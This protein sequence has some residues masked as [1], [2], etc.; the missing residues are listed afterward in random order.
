MAV[1]DSADFIGRLRKLLPAR[2]FPD[3]VPI[4]SA[5]LAGWAD[6]WAWLYAL[7]AYAKSQARISTASGIWL[8]IISSDFFAPGRMS[9]QLNEPDAAFAARI[10]REILRPRATR[11]AVSE[12]LVDLT[13]ITPKIFEPRNPSDTGGYNLGGVG[14]G[15]AGGWGD[16]LLPFQFFITAF[17]PSGG[18]VAK[19]AGYGNLHVGVTNSPGGYGSG[20]IQYITP[21]MIAGAVTDDAIYSTIAATIPA[22]TIA[23][24]QGLAAGVAG[25]GASAA[26]AVASSRQ[27]SSG[28]LSLALVSSATLTALAA[29]G[30]ATARA[31]ILFSGTIIGRGAAKARGAL[32]G[33]T[34]TLM[35]TRG[36]ARSR[37]ALDRYGTTTI[38]ARGT[39]A[40]HGALPPSTTLSVLP[41]SIGTSR[42]FGHASFGGSGGQQ[43]AAPSGLVTTAQTQSTVTLNW[44]PS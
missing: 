3:D 39:A 27:A 7:L 25:S 8:D 41:S 6:T 40:G 31:A 22:A 20:A 16:L 10:K 30:A 21:A 28:R 19:V 11:A 13:G 34:M 36:V 14:Y 23:W 12:A 2:W 24:T 37:G 15:V 33:M 5:I 9:R 35:A 4:L 1:G 18:G 26:T 42:S 43:P 32:G 17:R 38:F 29:R 44:T